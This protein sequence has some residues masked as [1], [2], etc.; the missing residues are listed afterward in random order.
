M[1]VGNLPFDTNEQDLRSLFDE[2]GAVT[3]VHIP[4]DRDSGQVRG[5]AF[6]TMDSRDSMD[7]AIKGLD[8]QDF[9]GRTLRINEAQERGAS[10]GGGGQRRSGGGNRV[11]Q[12]G[13]RRW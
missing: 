9:H 6:V 11:A 12:G 1:Y 3:D 2:Y 8:S 4:I 7:S 5:F 10:F 13:G